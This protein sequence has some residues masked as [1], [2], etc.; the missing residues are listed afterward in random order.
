VDILKWEQ[1]GQNAPI[2]L[3]IGMDPMTTYVTAQNVPSRTLPHAEYQVAGAWLG[4]PLELVKCRTNDLLVPAWSEIVIEGE[5]LRDRR[6]AEGPWGE[7]ADI[8]AQADS[9]FLMQ[10]NC[11]THRRD[12]INYGLICRPN[13][14][15]PKFLTGAATKS[16]LMSSLDYVK[17]AYAFPRTGNRPL[18]VVS[19]RIRQPDDVERIVEAVA[20]MPSESYLTV[21]PLWLVVVDEEADIRDPHDLFWRFTLAVRPDRDI[22]V[23]NVSGGRYGAVQM[24]AIDA[25][26]R[27]KPEMEWGPGAGATEDPP[28]ATTSKELK[29]RVRARWQ[30]LGLS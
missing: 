24:L 10:V 26:F 12:P 17:D 27:N 29:Q 16:Y 8:Y 15:Y 23:L 2:A 5:I 25:T 30:E 13:Q 9:V 21:K 20:T 28:V 19:A 1:R 14:D 6:T 4:E 18:T 7:N 22:K 3:A 11:I